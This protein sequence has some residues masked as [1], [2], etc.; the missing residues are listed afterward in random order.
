MFKNNQ[1]GLI[2]VET[3]VFGLDFKNKDS[4]DAN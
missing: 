3:V 1:N 4:S 2:R